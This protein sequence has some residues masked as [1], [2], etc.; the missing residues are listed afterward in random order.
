MTSPHDN[1]MISISMEGIKVYTRLD[2]FFKENEF[3]LTE[4]K[5]IRRSLE[6]GKPYYGGGGALVAWKVE[7]D[8]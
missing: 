1:M 2:S 6:E 3:T 8:R 5:A 7:I 4:K